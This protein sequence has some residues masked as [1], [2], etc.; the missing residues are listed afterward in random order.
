MG[1]GKDVYKE[2]KVLLEIVGNNGKVFL[3]FEFGDFFE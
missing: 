3:Y 1:V 2:K